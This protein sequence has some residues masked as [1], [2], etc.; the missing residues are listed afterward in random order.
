MQKRP[1][2]VWHAILAASIVWLLVL[3]RMSYLWHAHYRQI[4]WSIAT[5]DES[6]TVRSAGLRRH[7]LHLAAVLLGLDQLPTGTRPRTIYL[8]QASLN[9]LHHLV[10]T[11]WI[12]SPAMWS[13]GF[14]VMAVAIYW[15][16]EGRISQL[17][18]EHR[19]LTE[20]LLAITKGWGSLGAHAN[21]EDAMHSILAEVS[22]HTVVERA[23]IYRLTDET[24]DSLRLYATHGK[25]TLPPR[26]VP[27]LFLE[28]NRGLI[29]EV[30]TLNQPRY[31]GDD[32]SAGY[33][34]PGVRMQRVAIFPLRYQERSWGILLLQS[35]Q[36][37]WFSAHRDLLEVLAQEIAIAAASTDVAEQDRKH[38]LLEDRARLQA[39]ILA[40]VS[41]ELRTPLGLV[42][43]Y[44]ETLQNTG[45]RL[46]LAERKEFLSVAV[47]ETHELETLIDQ[48]LTM[49]QW[50][51]AEPPLKMERFLL[52]PWVNQLLERYS[53][54]D[55]ERIRLIGCDKTVWVCGDVRSLTTAVSDLIQNAL[56]YATGP[57][58]VTF[59]LASDGWMVAVRDYGPGVPSADMDK[60]FERFFRSPIHAQSE[61][62]GSGLGL[63]IVKRIADAHGGTVHAENVRD[64][65]G[66]RMTLFVPWATMRGDA[67]PEGEGENGREHRLGVDY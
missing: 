2:V 36:M 39:E 27:L 13:I 40:N 51:N 6:T 67:I 41:H 18:A 33:L 7:L 11:Q 14:M 31:S 37:G 50:D 61:V 12:I 22:Q 46:A 24:R 1:L 34:L 25:I 26:P 65:G 35:D 60:I 16:K 19:R 52:A 62:R 32:G 4:M 64:G 10:A 63:A 45:E 17:E 49:S 29:G 43:G 38:R 28:P 9:A 48:L 15:I 57:L 20:Q 58:D 30:L 53:I 23:A 21:P 3:A 5:L 47:H 44:L 66:F 55:R 54:W 8:N 59:R 56:K 42:K